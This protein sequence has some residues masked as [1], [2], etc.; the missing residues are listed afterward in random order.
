MVTKR[1]K[2][3][4]AAARKAGKS[5]PAPRKAPAAAPK[6]GAAG[7]S[8]KRPATAARK[9][10]DAPAP[11]AA[12]PAARPAVARP[13]AVRKAPAP[14]KARRRSPTELR[15]FKQRLLEER[16]TLVQAYE[17]TKGNSRNRV[18]DGTEDYIDYAVNSYDR[19]FL[20]SLT[21]LERRQLMLVEEALQRVERGGADYGRCAQCMAEIPARRLE[22]QPW[23]RYC[24]QCQELDEQGLLTRT[25]GD[26]EEEGAAEA[27]EAD[28]ALLAE[29]EDSSDLDDTIDEEPEDD[30]ADG[31]RLLND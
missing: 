2:K 9:G 27:G 25:E 18:E 13:A 24:I 29:S 19:E 1:S 15:K 12:K 30:A 8:G 16:Q 21:E 6:R 22:V 7:S 11:R 14:K 20:L 4:P 17:N 10:A 23:A 5:A 3:P 26:D 31:E 28:D